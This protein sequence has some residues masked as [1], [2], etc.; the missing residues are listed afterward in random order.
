M[1]IS[2]LEDGKSNVELIDHMGHDLRVANAARVSM[3]KE[4][5]WDDE[6][7]C[8]G[9]CWEPGCHKGCSPTGRKVLKDKD[10]G[11][12]SFLSRNDHWT[13][14]GHC[15][16][17]L[18]IKM[19]FFVAREW[20]RHE[21]GFVRNEMS[22]RYVTDDPEF[23]TPSTFRKKAEGVKQGSSDERAPGSE[24]HSLHVDGNNNE[25]LSLYKYL[26]SNNVA[27]EQARMILPI[28]TYTEFYETGS[29]YAYARL[30]R[31]RLPSDAQKEIQTYAKA[32]SRHMAYLFPHAW[33]VLMAGVENG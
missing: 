18:R 31:Q 13:P 15:M 32:V 10:S 28:N 22:R 3:H 11:L 7:A 17:T 24:L 16:I 8:G 30:C 26:L 14:F 25:S 29:L 5:T 21:V 4:S 9:S 12:L 20:F 23:Y 1:K 27:P 2:P 6:C 19:P 33:R